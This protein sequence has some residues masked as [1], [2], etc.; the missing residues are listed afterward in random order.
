MK[1][2]SSYPPSMAMIAKDEK[3]RDAPL[4][5]TAGKGGIEQLLQRLTHVVVDYGLALKMQ[6]EVGASVFCP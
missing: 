2:N 3:L 4:G 6:R 1:K 5:F